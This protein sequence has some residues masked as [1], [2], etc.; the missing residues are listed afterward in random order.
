MLRAGPPQ[1]GNS[2]PQRS[3]RPSVFSTPQ[4]VL[5]DFSKSQL[6][7]RALLHGPVPR[8]ARAI[9]RALR[10]AHPAAG[11]WPGF[12]EWSVER[13]RACLVCQGSR[14]NLPPVRPT[15]PSFGQVNAPTNPPAPG[16]LRGRHV[17]ERLDGAS[18][19]EPPGAR[20]PGS[21]AIRLACPN[22]QGGSA[23]VASA[24]LTGRSGVNSVRALDPRVSAY[25]PVD[26][27]Y[28]T[29][30]GLF[31]VPALSRRPVRLCQI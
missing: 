14:G 15:R 7:G 8:L 18:S 25:R 2:V 9:S 24:K 3:L 17:A 23:A 12:A 11:I 13:M 21:R 28:R 30:R 1:L 10:R 22:L 31:R 6:R 16:F 4:M 29:E 27:I 19:A 5:R 26:P 20:L